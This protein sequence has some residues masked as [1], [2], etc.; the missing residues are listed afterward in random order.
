MISNKKRFQRLLGRFVRS[1]L[2]FQLKLQNFEFLNDFEFEFFSKILITTFFSRTSKFVLKVFVEQTFFRKCFWTTEDLL[3]SFLMFGT[4]Q[5]LGFPYKRRK[6]CF[7]GKNDENVP[8]GCTYTPKFF[9][10][11]FCHLDVVGI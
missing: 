6:C 9:G 11:C 3:S 1:F 7:F 10:V 5:K 2:C 4:H 8:L